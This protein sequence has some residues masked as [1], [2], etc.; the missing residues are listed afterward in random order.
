MI[1]FRTILLIFSMENYKAD[2]KMMMVFSLA[3][4]KHAKGFGEC[5]LLGLQ[6]FIELFYYAAD[7]WRLA[8]TPARRASKKQT[9]RKF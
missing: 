6:V 8:L 2:A 3:C 4:F 7:I 5:A 1:L 9:F